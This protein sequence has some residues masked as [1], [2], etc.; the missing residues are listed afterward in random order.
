MFLHFNHYNPPPY[1]LLE[2]YK[3]EMENIGASFEGKPTGTWVKAAI[4]SDHI[5]SYYEWVQG[6]DVM[7]CVIVDS[8][9]EQILADVSYKDLKEFLKKTANPIFN[10]TVN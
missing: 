10:H 6:G 2:R 8:F 7:G 9:G 1:E 5:T 4:R 3:E